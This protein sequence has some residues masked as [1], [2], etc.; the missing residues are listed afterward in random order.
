MKESFGHNA[1]PHSQLR[2][3]QLYHLP[4]FGCLYQSLGPLD[5]AY[6]ILAQQHPLGTASQAASAFLPTFLSG[7]PYTR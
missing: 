6:Y 2:R 3:L 1:K 4:L 7:D 5:T